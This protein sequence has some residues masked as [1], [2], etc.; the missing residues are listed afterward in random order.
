M[1]KCTGAGG[2]LRWRLVDGSRGLLIRRV[3]ASIHVLD[4]SINVP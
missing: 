3:C 1:D 4:L 2:E